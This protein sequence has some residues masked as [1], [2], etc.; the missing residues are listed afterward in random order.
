MKLRAALAYI[1]TK[2]KERDLFIENELSEMGP[3]EIPD[4]K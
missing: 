2:K 4:G 3:G 1:W